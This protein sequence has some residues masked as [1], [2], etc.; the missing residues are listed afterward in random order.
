MDKLNPDSLILG[1]ADQ[2]IAEHKAQYPPDE[3]HAST[4]ED[5]LALVLEK[6][7]GYVRE[8]G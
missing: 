6:I 1:Y 8:G 3:F 5:L 2:L 7:V 4:L